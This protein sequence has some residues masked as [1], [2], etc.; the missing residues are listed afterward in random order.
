MNKY[1]ITIDRF[2]KLNYENVL[3]IDIRDKISYSHGFIPNAV[4]MPENETDFSRSD[5]DKNKIVV[6]YCAIGEKSKR[7]VEILRGKNITAYNLKGGFAAWLISNDNILSKEE[8]QRYSRQ[9]ILPQIGKLGQENLKKAKVLIV[10]AGGLGSPCTLYLA[11]AGIGTIGIIDGDNV[12]I[13]NLHRQILHDTDFEG[14][15]KVLS[16]KQ[17]INAVNPF[18]SVITY[19]EYILPENI[20]SIIKDYDFII[21]GADNVETKFLINDACV[22]EK[23]PFSY[24]GVVGFEGQVTTYVP[25]KGFCLRCVFED[26]P[27][28][29]QSCSSFGIIGA[30]AGIIGSIQDLEA[31]KYIISAGELLTERMYILD[32]LTMQGRTVEL[33][34]QKICKVCGENPTIK[35]MKENK[36]MY[37]R[38][39]CKV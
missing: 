38:T 30:M 19:D 6:V 32:G 3:L 10:G 29:V 8:L 11:A 2:K 33:K 5:T 39:V 15:K 16:A 28:D 17:R 7:I 27:K 12:D 14:Q 20:G 18:V 25:K 4:S 9:I 26:I 35:N 31:I 36:E 1:E 37:I 34:S 22:I 24:A 23:K 13:S 21:D